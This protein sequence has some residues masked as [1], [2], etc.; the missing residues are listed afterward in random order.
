[1]YLFCTISEILLYVHELGTYVTTNNLTVL[2][3][4]LGTCKS[5]ISV[6]IESQIESAAVIGIRI[7]N[8]IRDA[9]IHLVPQTI[10]HDRS[11]G[12]RVC[13]CALATAVT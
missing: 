1:M 2:Q 11:Y 6:R 9:Q 3:F 10:L 4:K 12:T 13:V 7:S 5:E 8:R